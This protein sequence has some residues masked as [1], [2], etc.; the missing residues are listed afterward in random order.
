MPSNL[1]R[2]PASPEL[3]A[4]TLFWR[5]LLSLLVLGLLAGP[6]ASILQHLIAP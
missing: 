5:L 3:T 2:Q 4:K 6:G 1:H